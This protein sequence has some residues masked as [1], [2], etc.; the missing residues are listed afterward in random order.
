[1]LGWLGLRFPN[2]FLKAYIRWF[3][4][5]MKFGTPWENT[6]MYYCSKISALWITWIWKVADPHELQRWVAKL[7]IWWRQ[8][9]VWAAVQKQQATVVCGH[10]SRDAALWYSRKQKT[11]LWPPRRITGWRGRL[12]AKVLITLLMKWGKNWRRNV[13]FLWCHICTLGI[14]K[15]L[16]TSFAYLCLI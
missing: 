16:V 5:S 15:G 8:V 14:G 11:S 2:L 1:M 9:L 12:Q 3:W 6:C 10:S 4:C 13:W 7:A